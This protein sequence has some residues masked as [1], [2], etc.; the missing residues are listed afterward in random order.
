LHL[1]VLLVRGGIR[2]GAATIDLVVDIQIEGHGRALFSR[3]SARVQA[4][5]RRRVDCLDPATGYREC[6]S[7]V[8]SGVPDPESPT[9]RPREREMDPRSEGSAEV[10]A[11][12]V[13]EE[14]G[15]REALG[16]TPS[17]GS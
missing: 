8:K 2:L 13:R 11:V 5:V 4:S 6:R 16:F 3:H 12:R 1:E 15:E 14:N 7:I 9:M 17:W 10:M